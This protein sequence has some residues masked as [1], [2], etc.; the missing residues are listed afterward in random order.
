MLTDLR[1]KE[2]PHP[3]GGLKFFKD[4]VSHHVCESNTHTYI[5]TR[6]H[7]YTGERKRVSLL[8]PRSHFS[9]PRDSIRFLREMLEEKN[10]ENRKTPGGSGKL[11]LD[12]KR[13]GKV[14]GWESAGRIPRDRGKE[15]RNPLETGNSN[16]AKL[17]MWPVGGATWP[18]WPFSKLFPTIFLSLESEMIAC[19]A[20]RG[21]KEG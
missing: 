17:R 3:V 19:R 2:Q 5:H 13:G 18:P 1:V 7:A 6:T 10:T 11:K 14:E 8:A 16:Q 20:K 21:C 15:T 12:R 9:Q 4:R